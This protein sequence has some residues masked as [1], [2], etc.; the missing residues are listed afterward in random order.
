MPLFGKKNKSVK[1]TEQSFARL[2]QTDGEGNNALHLACE[3]N[4]WEKMMTI[5]AES[6]KQPAK[7]KALLLQKNADGQ[8]PIDLAIS[9]RPIWKKSRA[10]QAAPEGT[11]IVRRLNWR[12]EKKEKKSHAEKAA[13]VAKRAHRK[14]KPK[15]VYKEGYTPIQK[16][17]SCG[18]GRCWLRGERDAKGRVLQPDGKPSGLFGARRSG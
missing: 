7:L 16:T 18:W 10:A 8:T 15:S 6:Y 11:K 3:V 1:Y 14:A 4:D 13:A 2:E 5:L 9:D 17:P 12:G